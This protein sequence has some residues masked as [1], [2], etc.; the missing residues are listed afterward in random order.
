MKL[1]TIK[2]KP[3]KLEKWRV[4]EGYENYMVSNMGRVKSLNYRNTNKEE[5]LKP[6]NKKDGYLDIVLSKQG[7]RKAFKIHRLVANAFIPNPL[8][9]P[10]VDHID[11]NRKN[12]NA[13]NL[14]WCDCKENNNNPLTKVKRVKYYKNI[15]GGDNPS[16]RKVRCIEKNIIFN[17]IRE[18]CKWCGLKG[19]GNISA[20]CNKK[21]K[22]AGGYH[23]EYVDEK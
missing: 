12:N 8:N 3:Q 4:I 2:I 13:K 15:R 19:G 14:R 23:W 5:I 18:A 11:T 22:T 1:T 6:I 21:R 9:R 20:C 7:K 17:T 16:A 10:Y